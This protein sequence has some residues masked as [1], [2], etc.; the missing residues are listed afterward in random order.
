MPLLDALPSNP[1]ADALYD[2]FTAWTAQQGLSLYP[3]Q[4]EAAIELFDANNVVLATPTGSGK[5]MVAVA[6]QIAAPPSTPPR[7]RRWSRRSSSPCAR[8]SGPRTSGC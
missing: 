2:A 1:S 5:S 6:A 4:E 7:S 8:S 3:H